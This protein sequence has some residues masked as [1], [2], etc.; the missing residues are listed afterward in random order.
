MEKLVITRK[1]FRE[2]SAV[3]SVRLPSDLIK[4]IDEIAENT[5]RSRNELIQIFLEFS[6]ENLIID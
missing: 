2:E 5:G 3:V 6:T 1:K 4:R